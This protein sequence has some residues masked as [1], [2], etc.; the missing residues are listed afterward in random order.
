VQ[1]TYR[2][3]ALFGGL[4]LLLQAPADA[5]WWRGRTTNS[6]ARP[7]ASSANRSQARVSQQAQQAIDNEKQ[8]MARI[9]AYEAQLRREE[10]LLQQRLAQANAIRQQGLQKKDQRLLD[11][12]ERYERQAM[13]AYQQRVKYFEGRTIG[14]TTQ[15]PAARTPT[16]QQTYTP[17]RKTTPPRQ[18]RPTRQRSTRRTN[19]RQPWDW[20][21]GWR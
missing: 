5:Q 16:R 14:S 20:L 19:S 21:R 1:R 15:Q 17:P 9:R 11:Q 7:T 13:A 12:A 8:V 18:A 2:L 4:L 6:T 3:L 10:Q